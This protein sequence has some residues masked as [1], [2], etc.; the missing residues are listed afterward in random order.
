MDDDS[1]NNVRRIMNPSKRPDRPV[2]PSLSEDRPVLPSLSEAIVF[3][4][5]SSRANLDD[6]T[7]PRPA[8]RTKQGEARSFSFQIDSTNAATAFYTISIHCAEARVQSHTDLSCSCSCPFDDARGA[9]CKHVVKCLHTLIDG[10]DAPEPARDEAV[11]DWP[12]RDEGPEAKRRRE[13]PVP[14]LTPPK[15]SNPCARCGLADSASECLR[16][17]PP[18]MVDAVARNCGRCGRSADGDSAPC[19]KGL[20]QTSLVIVD[21]EGW[22]SD[23]DDDD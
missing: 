17:H 5:A 9:W 13:R 6:V 4:G 23:D 21:A 16:R 2:L 18:S 8:G 15:A 11:R 19:Y 12:V 10:E 22:P 14:P 20:H 3:A 7:E 1:N